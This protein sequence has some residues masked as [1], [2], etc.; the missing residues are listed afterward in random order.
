MLDAGSYTP[1]IAEGSIFVVKGLGLS[2]PGLTQPP[3]PLPTAVGGVSIAFLAPSGGAPIQA[4]IDYLYN[5]SGLN[6]LAAI[7]P[8]NLPVGPY[9]VT[10]SY[11]GLVSPPFPVMVVAQSLGC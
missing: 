9:N 5:E 3:F 8:S 10:V 2:A 4:Y 11:N 6:Q 7:L 1:T